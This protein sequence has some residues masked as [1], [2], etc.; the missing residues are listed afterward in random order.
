[1]Q[2]I[3]H[4]KQLRR[5]EFFSLQKPQ[6]SQRSARSTNGEKKKQIVYGLWPLLECNQKPV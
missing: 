2:V 4:K 6:K 5:I 3:P 1:M